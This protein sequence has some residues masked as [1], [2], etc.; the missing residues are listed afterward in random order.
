MPGHWMLFSELLL[1]FGVVF[2]FGWHQLRELK[3]LKERDR[4]EDA[5][6][7]DSQPDQDD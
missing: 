7:N 6:S 4:L 3:K 1:T 5:K 2:G